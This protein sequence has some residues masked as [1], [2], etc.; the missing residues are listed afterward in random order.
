MKRVV[1]AVGMALLTASAFSQATK[2]ITIKP[3]KVHEKCLSLTPP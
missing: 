2:P 1:M 3:G